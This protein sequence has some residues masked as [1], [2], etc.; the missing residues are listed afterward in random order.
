MAN[1]KNFA[2]TKNQN[3]EDEK[4]YHPITCFITSYKIMTGLVAKY[5][6]EHTMEN[7]IWDEGQL[8]KGRGYGQSTD[9]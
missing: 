6:R 5:M 4:N 1:W 9:Y 8:G 7:E 2:I 3:L